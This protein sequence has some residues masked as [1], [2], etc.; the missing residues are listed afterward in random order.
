[1]GQRLATPAKKAAPPKE[2]AKERRIREAREAASAGSSAPARRGEADEPEAELQALEESATA[3]VPHPATPAESQVGSAPLEGVVHPR[4]PDDPFEYVPAPEDS[5]DLQH[6]AHAARQIKKIGEAAG[7]KFARLEAN[8]WIL[9]GRWLAEVQA[10]GSYKA[11]G[12]KSVD[13][14]AKSIDME[15]H[16]YYRAIKH[17][18]VYTALGDRLTA[19]LAQNLVDQL[20]SLGKDD[21]DLLRAKYDE[22]AAKGEVTVAAVKNLRR[23]MAASEEAAKQPKEITAR[24]PRPMTERLKEAR[25][26]GRLDLGLVQELVRSGDRQSAQEYIDDMRK[27]LAEAEGLLKS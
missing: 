23:L 18:V 15:R 14:F 11:G 6:L 4:E 13:A 5:D 7:E 17:H 2:T 22:L 19:P 24:Q 26:T 25:A 27:R 21:P 9:T 3:A 12:H 8:Y 10:K 16:T 1:M 20:Y